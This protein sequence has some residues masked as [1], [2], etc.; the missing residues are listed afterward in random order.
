MQHNWIT[1]KHTLVLGNKSKR[2]N[3][4]CD[5]KMAAQYAKNVVSLKLRTALRKRV[6]T[7]NIVIKYSYYV[8]KSV[9]NSNT[10]VACFSL[11][12]HLLHQP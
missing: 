12:N 2:Q 6:K 11:W 7:K 3:N 4:R 1:S 8:K 5:R 10:T 9:N